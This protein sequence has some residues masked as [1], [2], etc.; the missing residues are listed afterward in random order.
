[1][2][3]YVFCASINH[4]AN[5]KSIKLAKGVVNNLKRD[6][7]LE[8]DIVLSNY[9]STI[10]ITEN[11]GNIEIKFD[12]DNTIQLIDDCMEFATLKERF[13]RIYSTL[14]ACM[15]TDI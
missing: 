1:M 15:I 9:H 8:A 13:D 14:D 3:H 2:H 4:P 7:E 12:N 11:C 10:T 6:W 5:A